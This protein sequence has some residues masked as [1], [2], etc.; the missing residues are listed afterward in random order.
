MR[1]IKE[2]YDKVRKEREKS[3]INEEANQINEKVSSHA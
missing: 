3:K 1:I 2:F